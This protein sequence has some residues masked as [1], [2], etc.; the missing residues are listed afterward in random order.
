MQ[1]EWSC[2]SK[3]QNFLQ[4]IPNKPKPMSMKYILKIKKSFVD[5]DAFLCLPNGGNSPQKNI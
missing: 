2:K 5:V 1:P 4:K 3:I